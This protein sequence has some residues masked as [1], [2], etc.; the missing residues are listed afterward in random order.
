M[1]IRSGT[2][3][4]FIVRFF[5]FFFGLGSGGFFPSGKLCTSGR[6]FQSDELEI[7]NSS[8]VDC[9]SYSADIYLTSKYDF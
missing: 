7:L 5:V 2:G 8:T 4:A 3:G 6:V 9:V 1:R